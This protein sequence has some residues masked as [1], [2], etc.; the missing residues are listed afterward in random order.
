LYYTGDQLTADLRQF[1]QQ[2]VSELLDTLP[3]GRE[4]LITINDVS[5]HR[6]PAEFATPLAVLIN[7]AL[8]NAFQH[9][10]DQEEPVHYL[11]VSFDA[12][13]IQDS[14]LETNYSMTV[15]D[16]GVGIPNNIE[17]SGRETLGFAIMY[18]MAEKLSGQLTFRVGNG[19]SVE[20]A[21]SLPLE[22]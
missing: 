21:F 13:P 2:R 12:D 18:A 10:F 9:A 3:I 20:L 15:S 7:E 19:T 14:S 17:P 1:T 5:S 4:K 8:E 22:E 11:Q 16:N 6:I